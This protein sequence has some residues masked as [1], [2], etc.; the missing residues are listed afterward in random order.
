MRLSIDTTKNS[1]SEIMLVLGVGK[2][3]KTKVV[4]QTQFKQAELLLPAVKDFLNENNVELKDI[5]EIYVA[6]TAGTFTALRLGVVT[7][8]ALGYALG[9]PVKG[10]TKEK[11]ASSKKEFDVVKPKYSKEPN[12]TT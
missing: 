8:N 5:S 12:I 10:V 7:A 3:K 11:V 9:V 6:N 1:S 4:K 2:S